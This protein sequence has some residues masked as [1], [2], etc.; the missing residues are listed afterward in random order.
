MSVRV[1]VIGGGPSGL[2][3]AIQ[4]ARQGAEVL[5][6]EQNRKPGRKLLLT[7]NGRCNLT[8]TE[9]LPDS[10]RGSHPEFSEQAEEL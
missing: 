6:L 10:Y 9:I 1:T 2:M 4:A 3:A 5:L 7:G 8:N